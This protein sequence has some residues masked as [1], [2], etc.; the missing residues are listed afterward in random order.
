MTR[1]ELRGLERA[2]GGQRALSLFVD[3]SDSA[4]ATMGRSRL[5]LDREISRAQTEALRLA[6]GERTAVELCFAH[7]RTA[8]ETMR[9]V[10]LS[11]GWVA[12]ATTDG[13]VVAE[14]VR[15]PMATQVYWQRGIVTAPLLARGEERGAPRKARRRLPADAT[16]VPYAASMR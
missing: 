9:D 4:G 6:P 3:T 2:C 8:I 10:P 15:R 16:G 12:Y 5:V 7:V 13:A 14:P 11:L 1:M